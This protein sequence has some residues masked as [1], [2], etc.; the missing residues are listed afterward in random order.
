MRRHKNMRERKIL[1][2][3]LELHFKG[4]RI[5]RE[6]VLPKRVEAY[7]QTRPP[8][9]EEE[10][11]DRI[12]HFRIDAVCVDNS[13]TH[14]IIEAKVKLNPEAIGQVLVFSELYKR[15]NKLYGEDIKRW[16]VCEQTE[17][18]LEKLCMKWDIGVIVV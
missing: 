11:L 1:K 13:G 3:A 15:F 4:M 8:T 16:I 7:E 6:Y 10:I 5:Y 17:E 18:I 12:N 14:H 2:R 9:E